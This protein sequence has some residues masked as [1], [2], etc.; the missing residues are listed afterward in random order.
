MHKDKHEFALYTASLSLLV[1]KKEPGSSLTFTDESLVHRMMHVLRLRS[2]DT[3]IFFDRDMYI[4]ATIQAFIGKKQAKIVIESIHPTVIFQPHIT[5]L[6][7]LLK[8]EDYETA[9]YTL[10]EVGVNNIQLIF[11]QKTGNKW[12]DERDYERAERIIIAAAEQSKN[13]AYPQLQ[14]PVFL[15]S[16]LKKYDSVA[17]KLFFDPQGKHFFDVMHIAHDHK[18][19]RVVLLVGPEGDL[20]TEEKTMVQA[21]KFI[22]CALT[23]TVLRAVQAS[24]LAS[25]FIRS[26]LM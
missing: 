1:E 26:V 22:F 13:F 15:E 2:N 24:A 23:P 3:C 6:L 7:P 20:T 19:E 4:V 11:T 17:T 16:A 12:S 10:T 25:G 5:F 9:L 21:H 18:P 14:A 8:R